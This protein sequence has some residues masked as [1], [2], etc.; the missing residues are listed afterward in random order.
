MVY[1]Y[2]YIYIYSIIGHIKD[3][4]SSKMT[5]YVQCG[6]TSV[7][8][9]PSRFTIIGVMATTKE[10]TAQE[11]KRTNLLTN[12]FWF[13]LDPC[14]HWCQRRNEEIPLRSQRQTTTLRHWKSNSNSTVLPHRPASH[15]QARRDP[16]SRQ[17]WCMKCLSAPPEPE[18]QG[19]HRM[20]W[21]CPHNPCLRKRK[22]RTE[23]GFKGKS[24]NWLWKW[25]N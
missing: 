8:R 21:S 18:T 24:E 6:Q 2:I 4:K 1:I 14:E 9:R 11:N 5:F 22:G 7:N 20:Y 25:L 10:C 15:R 12:C 17:L 23:I 3:G 16:T 19:S 13:F